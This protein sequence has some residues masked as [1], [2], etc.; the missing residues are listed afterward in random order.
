MSSLIFT[1]LPFDNNRIVWEYGRGVKKCAVMFAAIKTV[2]EANPIRLS[3]CHKSYAATQATT[4]ILVHAG[5][6]AIGYHL[7][8]QTLAQAATFVSLAHHS[9]R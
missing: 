4:T 8:Y 3:R 2:A 5:L 6:L 1:S 7:A 9:A